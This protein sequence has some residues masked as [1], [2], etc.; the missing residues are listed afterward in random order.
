MIID[1]RAVPD[2]ETIKT[3]VCIDGAG[4]AGITPAKELA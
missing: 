2:D 1:F 3:D 4:T